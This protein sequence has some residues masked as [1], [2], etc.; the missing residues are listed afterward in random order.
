MKHGVT[1]AALAALLAAGCATKE[2]ASESKKVRDDLDKLEITVTNNNDLQAQ[3]YERVVDANKSLTRK[4]A[5]LDMLVKALQATVERLEDKLKGAP[6]AAATPAPSAPRNPGQAPDPGPAAPPRPVGEVLAEAEAALG[7]LRERKVTEEEVANRLKPYAK[8]AAPYLVGEL[9]KAVARIDTTKQLETVLSKFPAS[10]LKVPLQKALDDRAIRHSAARIV[11]G[12]ADRELSRIL[13]PHALSE[14][15][16]FRLAVGDALVRSRNAA[17][18]PALV[19]SLKSAQ[20]DT[21]II[22]ISTLKAIN[23]GQD[24]GFKA[25]F[26]ADRNAGA[27]RMWEEWSEKFGKTVFD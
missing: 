13:E 1:F 10:D 26:D 12:V 8:D 7:Q 24:F 17:G 23:R 6:A 21:R 14:D 3:L 11:A 18:V 5:E 19:T 27:I 20:T 2:K 4:V 9:R 15:E 22:A 16:D 25:P